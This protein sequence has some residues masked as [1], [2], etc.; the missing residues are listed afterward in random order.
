MGGGCTPTLFHSVYHYVQSCGVLSSW[1]GQIH[2]PYFYSI[3]LWVGACMMGMCNALWVV[4]LCMQV[5]NEM[6]GGKIWDFDT[7]RGLILQEFWHISKY[8][9]LTVLF[10]GFENFWCFHF[11]RFMLSTVNDSMWHNF[12]SF[13]IQCLYHLFELS[14]YH[15][16]K[17]FWTVNKY[18]ACACPSPTRS[19]RKKALVEPVQDRGTY[20]PLP[21]LARGL[22][23]WPKLWVKRQIAKSRAWIET[24]NR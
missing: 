7:R 11:P 24:E 20:R 14:V 13:K 10:S 3:P 5:E 2:S 4:T 18:C 6:Y 19:Q 17:Y 8:I 21:L 22:Y 16:P 23:Y 9:T 1:E 12:R 15:N